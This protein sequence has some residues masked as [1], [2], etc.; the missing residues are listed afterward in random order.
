MKQITISGNL[1]HDPDFKTLQDGSSLVNISFAN[2]S[3]S[4][5]QEITE[6][7]RATAYGKSAEYVAK[8]AKKGYKVYMVGGFRKT[9]YTARDGATVR[10]LEI[11]VNSIEVILPK[12]QQSK[13]KQPQKQAQQ[14]QQAQQP[15]YNQQV[16]PYQQQQQSDM[17]AVGMVYTNTNEDEL[18]F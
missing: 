9:E 10:D 5:G 3:K 6:F 18:P 12:L 1:T 14:Y 16:Q 11:M 4:K 13:G 8:Y 7:Y 2:N 17:Q 15:Q